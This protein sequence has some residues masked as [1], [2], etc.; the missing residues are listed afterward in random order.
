MADSLD[1]L[2]IDT[3]VVYGPLATRNSVPG[4][5]TMICAGVAAPAGGVAG[6]AVG[7]ASRGGVAGGAG[8][9]AAGGVVG[10]VA[11][12]GGVAAGGVVCAG[13]GAAPGIRE[14]P[15]G[16]GPTGFV[17]CTPPGEPNGGPW[18]PPGDMFDG[19]GIPLA[20]GCAAPPAAGA[21]ASGCGAISEGGPDNPKFVCVPT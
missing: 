17:G 10:G 18:T 19:D 4:G 2:L 14:V 16:S 12:A 11:V 13:A 6:A 1:A 8:T 15:G 9:V 5:V 3:A 20:D 7:A 21:G